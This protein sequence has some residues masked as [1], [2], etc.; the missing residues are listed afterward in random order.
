MLRYIFFF[1]LLCHGLI[2]LMGFARA[3]GYSNLTRI[4]S[5]ISKKYGIVWLLVC[6]LLI[7]SATGFLLKSA[8]WP[9]V[10]I[11]AIVISQVVIFASWQDSKF[12]TIPNLRNLNT[13]TIAIQFG[14]V[15]S[16]NYNL[17]GM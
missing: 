9:V 4:S 3:F 12:G 13:S 14:E 17:S 8:W 11:I 1:L 5:P 10:A 15:T 16:L 7:I 2:H 6:L